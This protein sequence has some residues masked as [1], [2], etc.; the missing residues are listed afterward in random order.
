MDWEI[1]FGHMLTIAA[2]AIAI[3]GGVLRAEINDAHRDTMQDELT[4][5]MSQMVAQSRD[6]KIILTRLEAN[7]DLMMELLFKDRK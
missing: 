6:D 7:Q 4:R 3:I 1:N 2:A 5:Q